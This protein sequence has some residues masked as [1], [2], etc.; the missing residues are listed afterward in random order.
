MYEVRSLNQVP[1]EKVTLYIFILLIN[2]L[3]Y[4]LFL[5]EQFKIVSI[6]NTR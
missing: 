3:A 4:I 1:Y 6:G 5:Y 2:A